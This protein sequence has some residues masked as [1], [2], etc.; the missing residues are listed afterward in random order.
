MAADQATSSR[1]K[2]LD[3]FSESGDMYW[4]MITNQ[5]K[6]LRNPNPDALREHLDEVL[7]EPNDVALDSEQSG[8]IFS[9][10]DV[11]VMASAAAGGAA[12]H[13]AGSAASGSTG[14]GSSG[15]SGSG[16]STDSSDDENNSALAG[17]TKGSSHHVNPAA[18]SGDPIKSSDPP[19]TGEKLR[20]AKFELL[21]KLNDLQNR[22][23]TL[24][25]DYNMN[26]D[27]DVMQREYNIHLSIR[28]KQVIVSM[29]D[30]GFS[31]AVNLTEFVNETYNPFNFKLKG[32]SKAVNAERDIYRDIWGDF[33]EMYHK[34][35]KMIHPVLRLGFALGNTITNHHIANSRSDADAAEKAR[36]NK[37]IEE[38]VKMQL[39]SAGLQAPAVATTQ[40]GRPTYEDLQ[41]HSA[42]LERKVAYLNANT[43]K[44]LEQMAAHD[45]RMQQASVPGQSAIRQ[46]PSTPQSPAMQPFGAPRY[47]THSVTQTADNR[48]LEDHLGRMSLTESKSRHSAL[49]REQ[50]RII[51]GSSQ[52]RH[53]RDS[54][55]SDASDTEGTETDS[56]DDRHS[57]KSKSRGKGHMS[58]SV[59]ES[60]SSRSSARSTTTGNSR[61]SKS[62]RRAIKIDT[63]QIR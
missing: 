13:V 9:N 33:Y 63:E 17:I 25:Q 12:A 3:G 7:E 5:A 32:M 47:P 8:G 59:S 10:K 55:V 57:R 30:Q 19:L 6:A 43:S 4:G 54:T 26:S 37:Y 22:G 31:G 15:S 61:T 38:Q 18:A 34:N 53:V 11:A 14:S 56:P 52:H 28:N 36:T 35:D 60:Q 21:S 24:S 20:I 51:K 50:D 46:Q 2:P 29:Y 39:A 40:A 48:R 27:Y 58:S 42:E 44:I 16:E 49:M 62:K 45:R 23:V 41:R 1:S